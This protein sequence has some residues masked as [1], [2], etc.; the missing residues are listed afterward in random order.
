MG[1]LFVSS[2]ILIVCILYKVTPAMPTWGLSPEGG[3]ARLSNLEHTRQSRPGSGLHFQVK[4][5]KTFQV[6]LPS[7]GSGTG[8]PRS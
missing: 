3:A 2:I 7:L 1:F 5:L 4:I 6:V 8:V